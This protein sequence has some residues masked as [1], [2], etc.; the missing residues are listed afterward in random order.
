[1][2]TRGRERVQNSKIL[3]TRTYFMEAP[4]VLKVKPTRM[5]K[6]KCVI[7]DWISLFSGFP[8]NAS[9]VMSTNDYFSRLDVNRIFA[10]ILVIGAR[11]H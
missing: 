9:N 11:G 1:M 5:T 8:S 3:R 7:L 2:R 4:S 10:F 6:H